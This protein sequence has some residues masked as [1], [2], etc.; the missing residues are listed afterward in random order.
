MHGKSL[1]TITGT[2]TYF[3]FQRSFLSWPRTTSVLLRVHTCNFQHF[4]MPCLLR[5]HARVYI[6]FLIF[7]AI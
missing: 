7:L 5:V 6:A 3:G 4:G 1:D 2:Q